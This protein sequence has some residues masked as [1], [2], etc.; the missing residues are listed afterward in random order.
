MGFNITDWLYKSVLGRKFLKILVKPKWS[1]L[2]GKFMDSGLSVFLI[3]P[4]IFK[5]NIDLKDFKIEK[6][7][8]FNEFFTRKIKPDTRPI[9]TN[10]FSFR[11]E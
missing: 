4:F 6:W 5:N 3:K 10:R 8:S 1:I 9:D 11:S 2:M 7:K